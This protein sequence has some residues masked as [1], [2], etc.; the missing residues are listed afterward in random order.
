MRKST[1][2]ERKGNSARGAA[3]TGPLQVRDWR[4]GFMGRY[5]QCRHQHGAA[6]MSERGEKKRL[7]APGCI[8]AHEIAHAPCAER[9]EGE[10]CRHELRSG[11]HVLK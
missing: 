10:C 3:S 8:A 7:E 4:H 5:C 11:G 1:I 2:E 6:E 9:A